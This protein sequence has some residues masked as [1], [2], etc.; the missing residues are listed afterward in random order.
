[1]KNLR[2]EKKDTITSYV[3]TYA[4]VFMALKTTDQMN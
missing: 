4:Y 1:M 3:H 2:L